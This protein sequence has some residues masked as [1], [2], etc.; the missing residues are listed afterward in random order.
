M[1]TKDV[2]KKL[3]DQVVKEMYAS[4]LYLNMSSWCYTHRYDGA[5]LFLF[6]HAK[7]ESGHA[8]KLITYLNETD[9]PLTLDKVDKPESNFKSLLD[10]FEKT[11][12]H[13]IKVT[14]SINELVELAFST[15]DYSTFN[16]LQ[17]YVAE[18]HEEETLFRGIK[19]KIKL[20]GS[21]DTSL[22]LID[23]Y[24]KGLAGK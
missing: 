21:S 1:L 7:E 8:T 10:V 17:W 6:E 2:I 20:A 13:E 18:Q 15:K 16:F 23:E 24:I 9:S 12:D 3:N 14:K 22:Y 5:G 19:D 4:N 11:Y